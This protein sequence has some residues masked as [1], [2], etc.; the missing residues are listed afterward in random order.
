MPVRRK[1]TRQI[2]NQE[3]ASDSM[4]SD[5]ALGALATILVI[6][7]SACSPESDATPDIFIIKEGGVLW[8]GEPISCDE[9]NARLRAGSESRPQYP[10]DI[11]GRVSA[12]Q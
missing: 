6:A 5:R 8:N 3:R 11:F 12:G 4:K 2:K 7:L 9:L 10:C 1:K